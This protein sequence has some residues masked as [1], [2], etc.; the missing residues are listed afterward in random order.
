M[1]QLINGFDYR[2]QKPVQLPR[3]QWKELLK[4]VV[5]AG[6]RRR[7]E[8]GETFAHGKDARIQFECYA[9]LPAV[10]P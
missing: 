10:T 7:V 6:G 9:V 4:Q 1:R 3:A 8:D 2:T 5:K